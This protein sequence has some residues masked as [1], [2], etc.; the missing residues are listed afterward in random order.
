MKII[1]VE[2]VSPIQVEPV[3]IRKGS[4]VTIHYNGFLKLDK[5]STIYLHYGYGVNNNWCNV[6]QAK[7]QASA[8]GFS[9][10]IKVGEER[11]L[12]FCFHDNY[13]RWDNNYGNNWSFEL[14]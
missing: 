9:A 2:T 1:G 14:N 12:N 10:T 3:P 6:N 8:K 11:R 13:D 4:R 7:M 5:S